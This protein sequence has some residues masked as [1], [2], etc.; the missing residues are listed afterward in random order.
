MRYVVLLCCLL[1]GCTKNNTH[2]ASSP[3]YPVNTIKVQKKDVPIYSDLIG[4][5]TPISTINIQSRVKGQLVK[6]YFKEGQMVKKG[7][8]LFTIDPREYEAN[9]KKS[10]AQ[11]EQTLALQ[12]L[13][14]DKVKRF[15]PLVK[16]Q[17][18]SQNDY[19]SLVQNNASNIA[20]LKTDRA[21][22]EEARINL[23]Y[24]YIH[25]PI[26]GLAGIYQIDPGN[27]V[28]A[29]KEETLVTINQLEPIY[30]EF[31]LPE[32]QLQRLFTYKEKNPITVQVDLEDEKHTSVL[33]KLDLIDNEVTTQTGTVIL[34]GIFQNT[35]HRLWPGEFVK[36]R[37]IY[38]LEKNALLIPYQCVQ[39]TPSGPIVY[40]IDQDQIATL[41]LVELGQREGENIIVTK[42]L[43]EGQ[44]VV[45]EGQLNLSTGTK[46]TIK[47]E[48]P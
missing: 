30:V 24:C 23:D 42:G 31:Y 33:G 41:V 36:T 29:N 9:L 4:H 47:K 17:Y 8:L 28:F 40:V 22:I 18:Y 35:A 34:R 16:E 45:V 46:V 5:V 25:S 12:R 1:L 2:K 10:Q 6:A 3:V 43:K 37:L 15:A 19:D 11:Y 26:D 7:D 21:T 27:M 48:M 44:T 14:E 38:T 39:S 20:K 13:S 32:N